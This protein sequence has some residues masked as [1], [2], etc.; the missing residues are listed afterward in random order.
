MSPPNIPYH[1][2]S[3]EGSVIHLLQIETSQDTDIWVE[4]ITLILVVL[5]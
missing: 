4:Y 1:T 2:R 3:S 5:L